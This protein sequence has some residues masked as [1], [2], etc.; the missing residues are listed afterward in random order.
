MC[1]YKSSSPPQLTCNSLLVF[2]QST[3]P[4]HP[5]SWFLDSV[6]QT[7]QTFRLADIGVSGRSSE[8]CSVQFSSAPFRSVLFLSHV[9]INAPS[10]A[11]QRARPT[12]VLVV[13][14]QVQQRLRMRIRIRVRMLV[15]STQAPLTVS[16]LRRIPGRKGRPLAPSKALVTRSVRACVVTWHTFVGHVLLHLHLHDTNVR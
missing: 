15:Y 2:F 7:S 3:I 12:T 8:L 5:G 10:D 16:S 13:Q 6:R 11:V 4:L 9:Y 14:V 1:K